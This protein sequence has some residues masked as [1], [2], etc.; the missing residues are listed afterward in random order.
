MT[1]PGAVARVQ[2]PCLSPC[3][4][5]TAPLRTAV[6][7]GG[8]DASALCRSVPLSLRPFLRSLGH[9]ANVHCGPSPAP[10]PP[11][12]VMG[13]G[14]RSAAQLCLGQCPPSL[15]GQSSGS[16]RRAAGLS[17]APGRKLA[18]WSNLVL[19]FVSVCQRVPGHV[20]HGASSPATPPP[21]GQLHCPAPTTTQERR[22][23]ALR[24]K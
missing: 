8:S 15:S 16:G 12:K 18:S 22:A 7:H 13:L 23:G 14:I 4:S 1:P 24:K 2:V 21:T 19:V 10:T 9:S 17:S 6:C 5:P 20:N 11:P 3:F